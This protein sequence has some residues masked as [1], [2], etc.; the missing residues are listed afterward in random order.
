M[1][2]SIKKNLGYQVLFQTIRILMPIIT[3]PIVSNALGS[4]GIGISLFSGSIAEYFV[5]FSS[6]GIGIYGNREIAIVRDDS[7]KLTRTF[8]ELIILKIL[9]TGTSLIGYFVLVQMF[10]EGNIFIYFLQ[11]FHIL[12]VLFDISWFFMGLEDFKKVTLSN[13]SIQVLMFLSIVLFIKD[14]SDL[15]LY[16]FIIALPTPYLKR[17][18]GYSLVNTFVFSTSNSLLYCTI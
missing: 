1:P 16:V 5:L 13:L 2:R 17:S 6:L 14:Y 10:F 15:Y 9:T 3:I 11:S 18:Y 7:E 4:K 12:A 8:S